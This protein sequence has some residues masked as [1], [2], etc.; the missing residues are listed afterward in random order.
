M[1]TRTLL[2]SDGV[3]SLVKN[4]LPYTTDP[5]VKKMKFS[6]N[7]AK[8]NKDTLSF[9]MNLT[10]PPLMITSLVD[11]IASIYIGEYIVIDET[12][13]SGKVSKRGTMAVYGNDTTKVKFKINAAKQKA[14]VKAK[15]KNVDIG[16][17]WHIQNNGQP[18][19]LEL[20]VLFYL[21]TTNLIGHETVT[22]PYTNKQDKKA[23]GKQ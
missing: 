4:A 12:A 11:S 1:T 21:N 23:K 17:Y 9:A 6:V 20:P 7:F 13:I 22:V 18:G 5:S 8:P 16:S 3:N 19:T 10:P 15:I 2:S 14:T